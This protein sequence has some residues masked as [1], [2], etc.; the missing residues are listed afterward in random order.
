MDQGAP[1]RDGRLGRTAQCRYEVALARPVQ[2][3]MASTIAEQQLI[4][5]AEA[6][7]GRGQGVEQIAQIVRGRRRAG[8]PVH[9][10]SATLAPSQAAATRGLAA[11]GERGPSGRLD[12]VSAACAS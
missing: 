9:A 8:L 7:A 1:E 2:Q 10:I 5:G 4:A 3:G 11:N 12:G 6:D